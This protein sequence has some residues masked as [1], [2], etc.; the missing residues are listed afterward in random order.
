[1]E[2]E[3]EGST[4]DAVFVIGGGA[5]GFSLAAALAKEGRQV[6]LVRTRPRSSAGDALPQVSFG[7]EPAEL[8]PV[9]TVQL[10]EL[11]ELNGIVV[12]AVKSHAN[13]AVA[14]TLAGKRISGP[15]VIL[16]NGLGVERPFAPPAFR[17]VLRGV[18]YMT[19]Q[20][21]PEGVVE[22]RQIASSPIG[23]VASSTTSQLEECVSM[24]STPRFAFHVH[25]EIAR[26]VWKKTIVN[27]AFN[28]I[29]PLLGVDNG[30][31]VRDP[32]VAELAS[33][34][35]QECVPLARAAGL[36][37]TEQEVMER[38]LKISGGST[39]I[40]I[41]TLQDLLA[42]RETEIE[43]LNL[44]LARLGAAAEPPLPM[45]ATGMLGRLVLAKSRLRCEP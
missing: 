29:C 40:L 30:I 7:G 37:L 15:L 38:I 13:A 35:V 4:G 26:E 45:S 14:A 16:Q 1:M 21:T 11:S 39:G 27:A 32:A 5:V 44:E 19:S 23:I 33:A 8:V 36:D 31:F 3:S 25:A 41:S 24:L 43:S 6:S 18:L 10:E 17:E 34:V 2:N 9:E 22:F 20:M 42:G 28:S 12:L